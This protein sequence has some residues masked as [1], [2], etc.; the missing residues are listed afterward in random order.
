MQQSG[1]Q[2][3]RKANP[4][5][6]RL[7]PGIWIMIAVLGVLAMVPFAAMALALKKSGYLPGPAAETSA[8]SSAIPVPP[9]MDLSGLR[10]SAEKAAEKNLPIPQLADPVIPKEA[11]QLGS[12]T[13][14]R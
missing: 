13:Q 7:T 1:A 6:I 11:L 9:T 3:D 2:N 14:S 5:V 4:P 12:E 8:K 10:G